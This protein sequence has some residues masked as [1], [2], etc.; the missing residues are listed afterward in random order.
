MLEKGHRQVDVG[1]N[2]TKTSHHILNAT[3]KKKQD[4]S[5]KSL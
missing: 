3:L 4:N 2:L 1:H 5:E